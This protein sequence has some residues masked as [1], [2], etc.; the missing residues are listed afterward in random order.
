[1]HETGSIQPRRLRR[2]RNPLVGS[3]RCGIDSGGAGNAVRGLS[4]ALLASGFSRQGFEGFAR[5]PEDS[6]RRTGV[7]PRP[8]RKTRT[9]ASTLSTPTGIAGVRQVRAARHPLLLPRL[10][11][12]HR[13]HPARRPRT[14]AAP[15]RTPQAPHPAGSLSGGRVQGADLRLHGANRGNAGVSGV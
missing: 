11:L 2:I 7:V 5:G 10:A 14:T 8:F 4:A 3:A 1:M 13:R 12:R 9:G 15:Q 6:R